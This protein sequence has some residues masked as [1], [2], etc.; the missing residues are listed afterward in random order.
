MATTIAFRTPSQAARIADWVIRILLALSFISAGGMKL[1]GVAQFVAMFDEIGFG[2]W[3]RLLTG[4]I[5]VTGGVLIIVPRTA[6]LGALLL[7]CVMIGAVITHLAVIGGN[8]IPATV[9]LALSLTVLWL[10]RTQFSI[11]QR[12][13]MS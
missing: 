12:S 10:R 9:L 3:F 6:V 7:A 1:A 8:P 2:Q 4:A 13:N 11:L 5:E